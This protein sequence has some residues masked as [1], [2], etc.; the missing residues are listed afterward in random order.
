MTSD[1]TWRYPGWPVPPQS[2]PA[3]QRLDAGYAKMEVELVHILMEQA[4]KG[5]YACAMFLLKTRANYRSS[6]FAA[7]NG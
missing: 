2:K 1:P 3:P 5:V 6:C 4:R 7:P